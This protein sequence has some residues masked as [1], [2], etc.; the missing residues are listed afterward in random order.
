MNKK[1]SYDKWETLTIDYFKKWICICLVNQ[2][3][4]LLMTKNLTN[5]EKKRSA[6]WFDKPRSKVL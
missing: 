6:A 3:F 1:L 2:N 5:Q 4:A